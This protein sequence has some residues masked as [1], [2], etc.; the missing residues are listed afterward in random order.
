L[1]EVVSFR[2]PR[3]LREKMRRYKVDWPRELREYIE[4]RIR[5]LEALE[6]LREVEE[7]AA[8]RRVRV[9]STLLLREEREQR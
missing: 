8:R 7:R 1:S 6:V 3:E 2:V 4:R 9:D 5:G